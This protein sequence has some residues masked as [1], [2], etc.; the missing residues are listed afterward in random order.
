MA[1]IVDHQVQVA[2]TVALLS[3]EEPET[4]QGRSAWG[5]L[6]GR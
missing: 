4:E 5:D 6:R 3:F 2:E 1:R